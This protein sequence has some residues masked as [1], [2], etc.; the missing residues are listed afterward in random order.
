[1]AE[2]ITITDNRTGESVE[3]P[4]VNGGVSAGVEAIDYVADFT[5]ANVD[6]ELVQRGQQQPGADPGP[7]AILTSA[8][9]ARATLTR[10]YT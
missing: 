1:M 4:I 9:N 5:A 7:A 8:S 6:C 3:I 2:S 10:L